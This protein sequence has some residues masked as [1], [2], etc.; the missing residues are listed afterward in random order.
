MYTITPANTRNVARHDYWTKDDDTISR[1]TLYW[2]GAVEVEDVQGI[3]A[4]NPDGINIL[5]LPQLFDDQLYDDQL[6]DHVDYPVSMRRGLREQ[7][8]QDPLGSGWV[9]AY[10]EIWFT[11]TLVIVKQLPSSHL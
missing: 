5:S 9:L 10:S 3:A 6:V 2:S 7:F 4:S 11:D 1:Y 8:E